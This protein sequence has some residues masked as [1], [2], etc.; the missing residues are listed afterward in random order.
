MEVDPRVELCDLVG[1][2]DPAPR[3]WSAID[4]GRMAE[5]VPE[6]PDLKMEQD[7]IHRHKDVLA[8]TIAVVA[9]DTG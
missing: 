9:K 5:L 7:P 2:D 8:H 4:C 1:G 6:L 3:L